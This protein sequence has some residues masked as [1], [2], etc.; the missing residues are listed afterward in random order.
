MMLLRVRVPPRLHRAVHV[1]SV[2]PLD[3]DLDSRVADSEMVIQLLID[4]AEHLFTA[5]DALFGHHDVATTTNHSRTNRPNM[6]IMYSEDAMN[7]SDRVLH[8]SH[9]ES[10]RYT[11]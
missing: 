2:T 6:Q 11:L 3:F 5:S 1:V 10:C 9:V 7:F 8:L 4:G